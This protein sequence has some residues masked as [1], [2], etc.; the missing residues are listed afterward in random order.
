MLD[1][2]SDQEFKWSRGLFGR[3]SALSLLFADMGC[4]I[5]PVREDKQFTI[6]DRIVLD[7]TLPHHLPLL[8]RPGLDYRIEFRPFLPRK[9]YFMIES[10]LRGNGRWI[11]PRWFEDSSNGQNFLSLRDFIDR[12]Y[13]IW[14]RSSNE[15]FNI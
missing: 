12:D 9:H 3:M 11:R 5:V 4:R 6:I 1:R 14:L 8:I 13:L 2:S 15:K 10:W 7:P